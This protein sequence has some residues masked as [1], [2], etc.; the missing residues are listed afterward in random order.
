LSTAIDPNM[1]ASGKDVKPQKTKF[2]LC[3]GNTTVQFEKGELSGINLTG[4]AKG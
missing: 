3:R 1:L 4:Q 2:G